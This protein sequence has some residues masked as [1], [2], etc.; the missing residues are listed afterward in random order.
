VGKSPEEIAAEWDAALHTQ[1]FRG[2]WL[3]PM[4]A[5]LVTLAMSYLLQSLYRTLLYVVYGS[6]LAGRN[7]VRKIRQ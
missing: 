6:H 7:R 1:N 3:S 4:V 2:W 5:I